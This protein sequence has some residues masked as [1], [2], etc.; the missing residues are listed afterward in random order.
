MSS[1]YSL[2][3]NRR[4]R[5]RTYLIVYSRV[6]RKMESQI[7]HHEILSDLHGQKNAKQ[8]LDNDTCSHTRLRP[9]LASGYF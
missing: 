1:L 3:Q 4:H 9:S 6:S 2:T 8:Q 5:P 7:R